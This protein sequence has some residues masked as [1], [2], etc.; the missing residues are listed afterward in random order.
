MWRRA[1]GRCSGLLG[2]ALPRPRQAA[3]RRP[4]LA[5]D[6]EN[7]NGF[8]EGIEMLASSKSES[9]RLWNVGLLGASL[10]M[11]RQAVARRLC[12][13]QLQAA[14][15]P[16]LRGAAAALWLRCCCAVAVHC[17]HQLQAQRF[18]FK[19]P[20]VLQLYVAVVLLLCSV[21]L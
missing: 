15:A 4:V 6:D 3:A 14:A 20:T 16:L 1:A 8:Q 7:F 17:V 19:D 2:P 10:A 13:P 12:L 18:C 9:K 11:A 5:A 21:M